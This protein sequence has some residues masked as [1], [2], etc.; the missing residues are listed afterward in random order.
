[1]P[2]SPFAVP[3]SLRGLVDQ[4]ATPRATVAA[5]GSP[6]SFDASVREYAEHRLA[7]YAAVL[8]ALV[9]PDTEL[10]RLAQQVAPGPPLP[11]TVVV[12]GGA[13]ALEP[14][15]TWATRSE[16]VVLRHVEVAVRESDAGDLSPNARRI[17]T[18]ADALAGA[19]LLDDEVTIRL[20][21]PRLHGDHPPVSWLDLLDEVAA[22]GCEL[23][24][25]TGGRGA[26]EHPGAGEL[27]ACI[28]AALDREIAFACTGGPASA[29][30]RR[31]D[32]T[33]LIE[34]GFLNV[35]A[36]TRAALDG[37]GPPD[38]AAV[39]EE[40]DP[41]RLVADTDGWA[42]ARRWFRSVASGSVLGAVHDLT[43][44][45]LLEPAS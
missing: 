4:A 9:V 1:M 41:A 38:V 27:G 35:L 18:A 16:H 3:E 37:A 45:G 33:G 34:H 8:G 15:V 2:I 26:R 32:G 12:S 17:L 23:M 7:P 22:A 44:L 10:P 43:A 25:R 6:G 5:G 39:L 29:V 28:T 11:L 42:S 30:R 31:D 13:G 21:P 36:A 19:G 40:R 14:A 24:L 20:T